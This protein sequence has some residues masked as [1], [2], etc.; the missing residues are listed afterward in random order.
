M[1][2]RI[3]VDMASVKGVVIRSQ[4]SACKPR[5]SCERIIVMGEI[6]GDGVGRADGRANEGGGG[7]AAGAVAN[8]GG[9]RWEVLRDKTVAK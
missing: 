5:Y 9:C 2:K 4:Q 7:G 3:L 8:D 6:R 1:Y